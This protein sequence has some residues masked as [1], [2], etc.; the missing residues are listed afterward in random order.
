MPEKVCSWLSNQFKK[1]NL[2]FR[3]RQLSVLL[4]KLFFDWFIV[5]CLTLGQVCKQVVSTVFRLIQNLTG[6]I[7]LS[8]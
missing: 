8:S 2:P 3:W 4:G 6:V 5:N 7:A 1:A